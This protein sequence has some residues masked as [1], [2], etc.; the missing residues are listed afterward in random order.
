MLIHKTQYWC[1]D[2]NFGDALNPY[3]QMGFGVWSKCKPAEYANLICIGS[4]MERLLDNVL[5]S[6]HINKNPIHVWSTGF[7]FPIHE[8][9]WYH[10]IKFPEKFAR[11]VTVHA[12]RGK[13]SLERAENALGH[14]INNPALGDGALLTSL[15]FKPARRKKYRLGIVG[16]FTEH[17]HSVFKKIRKNIKNS[18]IINVKS[19]PN[20]FIKKLT[21]C[22]A[23]ISS[24]LHPL[25]VADSFGIPNLWINLSRDK[26]ISMYKFT[27]YYSVFGLDAKY[28]DISLDEFTEKNL[29]EL[30]QNYAVKSDDV[31]KIQKSLIAAHPFSHTVN[32]ITP[33]QIFYLNGRRIMKIIYKFIPFPKLRHKLKYQYELRY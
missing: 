24:A 31:L 19:R 21:Q 23:I 9:K 14:K 26:N 13:L 5:I 12:L 29:A 28:M 1:D 20:K 15:I 25:V 8:H 3:I 11:N 22:D 10:N 4:S 7:H 18:I 16:H 33:L 2:N 32:Y 27:D 6:K 17:N 30:I